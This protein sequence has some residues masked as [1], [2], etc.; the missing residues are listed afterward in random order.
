MFG[1][2]KPTSSPFRTIIS[3]PESK[4]Q[5]PFFSQS[6]SR[7]RKSDIET[8]LEKSLKEAKRLIKRK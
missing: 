5:I 4:P 6:Q 3:K 1:I 7:S 8:E 2:S